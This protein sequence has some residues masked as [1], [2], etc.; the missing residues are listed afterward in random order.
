VSPKQAASQNREHTLPL[1]LQ[2]R[3]SFDVVADTETMSD[4]ESATR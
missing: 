2:C 1:I 4:E 3:E